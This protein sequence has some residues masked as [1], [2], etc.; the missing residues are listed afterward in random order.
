[1]SLILLLGHLFHYYVWTF[2]LETSVERA[3]AGKL[4]KTSIWWRSGLCLQL[5]V[6]SRGD[7]SGSRWQGYCAGPSPGGSWRAVEQTGSAHPE[8]LYTASSEGFKS[9]PASGAQTVCI[10]CSWTLGLFLGY[11]FT[12]NYLVQLQSSSETGFLKRNCIAKGVWE[13][14]VISCHCA[15]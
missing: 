5:V 2:L 9:I 3:Q 1:M 8:L 6:H 14:I 10:I 13:F 15:F 4:L 7:P 11:S 12:L